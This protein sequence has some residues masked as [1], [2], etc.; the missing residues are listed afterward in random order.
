MNREDGIKR[1]LGREGQK[2][3]ME[4][5][6]RRKGKRGKT[7]VKEKGRSKEGGREVWED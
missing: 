5:G 6:K 1:N 4:R 2:A 7:W 3:G